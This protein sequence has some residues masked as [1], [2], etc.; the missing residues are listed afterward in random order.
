MKKLF[1]L[2]IILLFSSFLVAQTTEKKQ[3]QAV[4]IS[5]APKID[6]IL[7][8]EI[9]NSAFIATDFTQI[10]PNNGKP[11][12][13]K[14]EVRFLY[15]NFALYVGLKAFD[16]APD[17]M[18]RQLTERDNL[19]ITEYCGIYIDPFNDGLNAYGF[20]LSIAGVQLDMKAS[21]NG[22]EDSNWS[23]VWESATSSN[24]E[25][26]IAEF[27]IPYSALRFPN[28][29][30][31]VWGINVFRNI[32]RNRENT[33]WSHLHEDGN[34]N[35][36]IY[37]GE[38][39]GIENITPPLRLSFTPYLSTY[40]EH[41]SDN[42]WVYSVKGG[43]DLKY[44]INESFTLDM[45]VIP[46]FGQVRSDDKVLNLS[47][48]ETYFGEQR[49]FFTEGT[50]LFGKAGIFY[51]RRIGTTPNRYYD[52]EDELKNNEEINENP[53]QTQLLN[54]TKIS[55]KTNGNLGIGFLNAMSMNTYAEIKDTITDS[56]RK[57]LTQ[58]FTNYNVFVMSQTL[59]NNSSVSLINT[60]V[61]R[62]KDKYFANV[63]GTEFK[64]NNAAQTYVFSG[65]GAVSQIFDTTT[66][67]YG[68]YS[69]LIAGKSSGKFRYS[70][71]NLI[72]NA[73]YNPNDLGYLD[74]N[75]EMR[76][77]VNLQYNI[78]QKTGKILQSYN[79]VSLIRSDRLT[80]LKFSNYEIYYNFN[81]MFTNKFSFGGDMDIYPIKITD[82]HESHYED[83]IFVQNGLFRLGTW[84]S[85]DYSKKYAFDLYLGFFTIFADD[86]DGFWYGTSQRF[87]PNDKFLFIY[88]LIRDVENNSYGYVTDY[89]VDSIFFGKRD[90]ST[91]TNTFTINY[92]FS[93]KTFF[94]FRMRHYW[95]LVEYQEY[96]LLDKDGNLQ[97]TNSYTENSDINYNAF[98]IDMGYTWQFA[99]GSELSLVWKN[100]IYP[101]TEIE[102][103][104]F[105]NFRNTI[106][107]PQ[108][109]S[110]SIKLLYY[111]DFQTLRKRT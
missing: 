10:R 109:N 49:P 87:R 105:R 43:L 104:Y 19:G 47:P 3:I 78:S 79:S 97:K 108:N 24:N 52:V 26:W 15:D 67:D 83:R 18:F 59:K 65:K 102:R 5:S 60:N 90:I 21:D 40:A 98:T 14:T 62:F 95:S 110:F 17:S 73:H 35:F 93:N 99:P 84:V 9:W 92:I 13:Q 50:E 66:N 107:A 22:N 42:Q 29:E 82:F 51:S 76:N 45:M 1:F 55:G 81:T 44:G 71:T 88:D 70:F 77:S 46:D 100:S 16:S 85:T 38:L 111:I 96:F 86:H 28:K 4:K 56:K 75:N 91:I 63:T 25:G 6:G 31:Q 12:S 103:N 37:N 41:N 11:G 68:F 34:S 23:A 7:D 72:K 74:R 57:M 8:E 53:S 69:S 61:S 64:F 33:S 39:S 106:E 80:P 30:T 89:N 36:M 32:M 2:G 48:Y 20:F 58:P 94:S 27:K 101:E 54:A